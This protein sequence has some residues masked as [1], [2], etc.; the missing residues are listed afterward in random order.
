MSEW[1]NRARDTVRDSGMDVL[2]WAQDNPLDATIAGV[3]V[4]VLGFAAG[5]LV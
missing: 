5:W 4:F 2:E 3:V 1:R